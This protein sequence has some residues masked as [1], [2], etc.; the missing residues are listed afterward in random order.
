[1]WGTPDYAKGGY[2]YR[3]QGGQNLEISLEERMGQSEEK[4]KK[5]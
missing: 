3:S 4:K 5:V 1:M 2:V